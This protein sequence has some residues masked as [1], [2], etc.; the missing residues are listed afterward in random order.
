MRIGAVLEVSGTEGREE[1]IPVLLYTQDGRTTRTPV[2]SRIAGG[3][4]T[5]ESLQAGVGD[6][7]STV[8]LR[9]HRHD[10]S[11][12][13]GE[14]LIVEASIKPFVNLLWAGTVFMLGGFLLGILK[15]VREQ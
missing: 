1:L 14:A 5:L 13:G 6:G 4:L 2:E 9:V 7:L 12:G 8:T 3:M 10:G 11:E 15:R